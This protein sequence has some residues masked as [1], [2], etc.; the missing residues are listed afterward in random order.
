MSWWQ[1][2]FLRP[3]RTLGHHQR[4][5]SSEFLRAGTSRG[6]RRNTNEG[7]KVSLKTYKIC[8]EEVSSSI[9]SST[10]INRNMKI[11]FALVTIASLIG[12]SDALKLN[13]R[14]VICAKFNSAENFVYQ[15]EAKGMSVRQLPL[16]KL[17]LIRKTI[18][19]GVEN[20]CD[21]PIKLATVECKRFTQKGRSVVCR[22]W[23]SE[24]LPNYPWQICCEKTSFWP[25]SA[26]SFSLK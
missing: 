7:D 16:D 11:A 10:V 1:L 15:L 12:S 14:A 19:I 21:E 3:R 2:A 20:G 25:L 8:I 4:V 9:L 23:F 24:N 5:W 17:L 18:R 6:E 26:E 22:N 13:K